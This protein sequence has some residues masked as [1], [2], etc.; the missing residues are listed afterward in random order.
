MKACEEKMPGLFGEALS[1]VHAVKVN[2]R[3]LGYG[4]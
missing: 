1:L 2:L 4:G 3:G